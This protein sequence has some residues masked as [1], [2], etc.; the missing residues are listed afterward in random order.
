M[1]AEHHHL[2][3]FCSTGYLANDIETH[4]VV[5][6]SLSFDIK[7]DLRREAMLQQAHEAV[8]V[9]GRNG[10]HWRRYGSRGVLRASPSRED[11]STVS[12]HARSQRCDCS[13]LREKFVDLVS[14]FHRRGGN[15][16][17]RQGASRPPTT[18]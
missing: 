4:L 15:R 18:A 7:R 12:V 14:Q 1:A 9:F 5:L 13:F 17:H 10:R 2:I 8:V 6:I 11:S 3:F 16:R